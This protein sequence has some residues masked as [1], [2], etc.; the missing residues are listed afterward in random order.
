MMDGMRFIVLVTITNLNIEQKKGKVTL[1]HP[2]KS[3]PIKTLKS[4]EK[5]SGITFKQSL[6]LHIIQGGSYMKSDI[7]NYPAIFTYADDGISIEFPDL[8]GCLTCADTDDEA[9]KNAKECLGLHLYGM[10]EDNDEIPQP[11]SIRNI[12]TEENE[13]LVM[14]EVYLSLIHI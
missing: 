7:Y 3:I 14:I 5:Q 1:R 10:E 8:P 13:C 11:T 2:A 12:K 4:I 9:L 6:S